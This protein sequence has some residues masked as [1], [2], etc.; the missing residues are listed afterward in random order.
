MVQDTTVRRR[1]REYEYGWILHQPCESNLL[2]AI[3]AEIICIHRYLCA[4]YRFGEPAVAAPGCIDTDLRT[5]ECTVALAMARFLRPIVLYP[6]S[7]TW[8]HRR[9][10]RRGIWSMGV[11]TSLAEHSGMVAAGMGDF[12]TL[13]E[14]NR[15]SSYGVALRLQRITTR[16]AV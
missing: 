5:T 11:F 13:P 9:V 3:T 6:P 8:P 12:G 15:G 14:K 16:Q 2:M 4:D 1:N 7:N 10:C